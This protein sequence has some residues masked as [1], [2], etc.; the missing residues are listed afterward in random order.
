MLK[1]LRSGPFGHPVGFFLWSQQRL[2]GCDDVNT[3]LAQSRA[4]TLLTTGSEDLGSEMIKSSDLGELVLNLA[5]PTQQTQHS[6]LSYKWTMFQTA[7]YLHTSA[8]YCTRYA[9]RISVCVCV[10]HN[11][12][13][14]NRW[15]TELQCTETHTSTRFYWL[16][17]AHKCISLTF[18]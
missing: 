12:M 14:R 6:L 18:V 5:T 15:M 10:S 2:S 8:V 1:I 3:L 13:H 9:I 17:Q 11:A 7:H 4:N 16:V